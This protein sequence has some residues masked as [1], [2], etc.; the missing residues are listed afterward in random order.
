MNA[1]AN[2]PFG[3][4]TFLV[5]PAVLTNASAIMLLSTS[6]RFGLAIDRVK[7][8]VSELENRHS[9]LGGEATLRLEHLKLAERRVLLLVRALTFLYFTVGSFVTASLVSLLGAAMFAA[10]QEGLRQ[11][12]LIASACAGLMGF[13][14][15][16]SACVI[17]IRE[18][19]LALYLLTAETTFKARHYY[20]RFTAS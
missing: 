10:H 9:E 17:L 16:V 13:A 2:N 15:L 5:A 7:A 3:L 20:A 19:R 18:S 14:G 12:A 6:N 11:V 8:I 4:L 1:F